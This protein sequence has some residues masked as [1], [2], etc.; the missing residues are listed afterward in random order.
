MTSPPRAEHLLRVFTH[1]TPH[2][3]TMLCV[4]VC[5]CVTQELV[6]VCGDKDG[7][8]CRRGRSGDVCET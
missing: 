3:S 4:C 7:E 6:F 5:V 2:T 1:N 8:L